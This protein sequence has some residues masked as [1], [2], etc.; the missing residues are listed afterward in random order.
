MPS[1]VHYLKMLK[2]QSINLYINILIIDS[3]AKSGEDFDDRLIIDEEFDRGHRHYSGMHWLYPNIFHTFNT[4]VQRSLYTAAKNTLNLKRN[5]GGGHTSWS[6][7]WEALLYARLGD[8]DS[9]FDSIQRILMKYSAPNMLSL[10]PALM[11]KA[12]ENTDCKT[13]F[14]ELNIAQLGPDAAASPQRG[15]TT[16]TDA[17]VS[18]TNL[19]Y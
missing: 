12:I 6:A 11:T 13:C 7:G 15:M 9:S 8:G 19:M 10:H 17:K 1:L 16:I 14:E 18:L 4:S 3:D 5:D 2:V